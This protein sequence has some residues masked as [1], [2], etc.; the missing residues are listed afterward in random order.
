MKSE[1]VKI[2]GNCVNSK[3]AGCNSTTIVNQLTEDNSHFNINPKKG[4]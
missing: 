4:G 3:R 2:I 1:L